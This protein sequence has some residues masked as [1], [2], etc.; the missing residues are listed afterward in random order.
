MVG[1]EHAGLAVRRRGG[2]AG[3]VALAE[4]DEFSD[5]ASE[6]RARLTSLSLLRQDA[7]SRALDHCPVCDST[8]PSANDTIAGVTRDLALLDGNL[9]VIRND[10]PAIRRLI[11]DQEDPLQEL[12]SE[13]PT[14]VAATRRQDAG[15]RHGTR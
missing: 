8:I 6:Q 5:Q 3:P 7:E 10:T 13:L 12:R 2:Q 1:F 15:H 14:H 9:G 4:N 11:A